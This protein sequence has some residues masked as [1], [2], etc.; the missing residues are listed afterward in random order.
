MRA[1]KQ[2][3]NEVSICTANQRQ[4]SEDWFAVIDIYLIL[5]VKEW[6]AGDCN[7]RTAE[8]LLLRVNKVNQT[9][10]C[11]ISVFN[12]QIMMGGSFQPQSVFIFN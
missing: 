3:W 12:N 5:Q 8:D 11:F 9:V 4:V 2:S 1:S 7:R 10:L 6:F